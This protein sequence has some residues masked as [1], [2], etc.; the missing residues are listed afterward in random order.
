MKPETLAADKRPA[1][2]GPRRARPSSDGGGA[3]GRRRN[4]R[5]TLMTITLFLLPALVLFVLLVLAPILL[6]AYASVF[7]WNG[8]G[9]LPTNFIGLDNFTR[10][11]EDPVFL[12]DLWRGLILIVLSLVVQLP[13]ALGLALL[14]N[15]PMR[16]RAFYRLLF[17][18]PYVLSEVIT[19]VLFTMFFSPERGLAN[20]M[21]SMIGLEELSSTWLSDPSSVM[22]SVFIVMTWKYFGF[23]MILYLAGRQGIPNELIEAAQLDGATGW[24]V[25]RHVTLPLLG[26]TIRI[27]A[28]LSIIG[29]IQLFD[30]VWVLTEG[31]PIHSSETMAITMFTFGFGRYQVGYASAISVVMFLISLVFALG[32]QR[33]VL[34]RDTEGAIT[35]M[36]DQR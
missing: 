4:R 26:P 33:F 8:F 23:H 21:L 32:Y 7:K 27:S 6:A 29:A 11:F 5:R 31:G 15:Q 25:F 2:P 34:R 16:G 20:E 1:Q 13:L 19:A 30:L 24:K 12:G 10:M 35:G 28:F 22:Y 3:A 14:L 9:G 18:A 36:R 17:F